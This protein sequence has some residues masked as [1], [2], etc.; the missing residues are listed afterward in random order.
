MVMHPDFKGDEFCQHKEVPRPCDVGAA[1]GR[2]ELN[3][4]IFGG[5]YIVHILGVGSGLSDPS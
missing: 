5:V 4:L 2:N 1:R 3:W